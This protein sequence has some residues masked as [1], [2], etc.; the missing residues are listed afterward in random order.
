MESIG[1]RYDITRVIRLSLA[2]TQRLEQLVILHSGYSPAQKN[3]L[4]GLIRVWLTVFV[5]AKLFDALD[6]HEF[7]VTFEQ[8]YLLTSLC[9]DTPVRDELC[10]G[11]LDAYHDITVETTRLNVSKPFEESQPWYCHP[12]QQI[13]RTIWWQCNVAV[14]PVDGLVTVYADGFPQLKC[15]FRPRMGS[16]VNVFEVVSNSG[17]VAKAWRDWTIG[18]IHTLSAFITAMNEMRSI[19]NGKLA[20]WDDTNKCFIPTPQGEKLVCW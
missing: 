17:S 2:E 6:Q 13:A 19:A 16:A 18:S 14:S 11:L 20:T 1:F 3:E 15:K 12:L 7:V 5:A 9:K 4:L 8:L 10:D